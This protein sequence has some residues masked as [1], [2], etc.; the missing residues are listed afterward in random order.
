[1]EAIEYGVYKPVPQRL[2][3]FDTKS[4]NSEQVKVLHG[5]KHA[6]IRSSTKIYS[7]LEHLNFINI[8]GDSGSIIKERGDGEGMNLALHSKKLL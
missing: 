7:F 1:M 6:L 4:A 5:M 8:R 2:T 3:G